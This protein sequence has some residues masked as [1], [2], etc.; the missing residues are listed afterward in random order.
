MRALDTTPA[1]AK[2]QEDAYR[3]LGPA[4]RF[5]VAM[6]LSEFAHSLAE[7][8]IRLRNPT[9]TSEEVTR[10]LAEMLYGVRPPQ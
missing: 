10:T 7:A 5:R 2:V 4:G 3:K 1:A 9:M 6:E 8:G